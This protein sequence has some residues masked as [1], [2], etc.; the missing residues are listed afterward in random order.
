MHLWRLNICQKIQKINIKKVGIT[1]WS[2]G[3]M[4][5]LYITEKRLRD[6][7]ISKDLYYAASLAQKCRLLTCQDYFLKS[8]TDKRN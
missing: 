8:S 6:V 3:G 4:N 1:G 2:R 7:L 5:S